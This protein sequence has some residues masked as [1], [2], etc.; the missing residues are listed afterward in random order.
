MV[1]KELILMTCS[2]DLHLISS[3]LKHRITKMVNSFNQN[4]YGVV[5]HP[6]NVLSLTTIEVHLQL[7]PQ[8]AGTCYPGKCKSTFFLKHTGF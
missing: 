7:S 4:V 8:E 3:C 1:K 6:R 5:L 2:F